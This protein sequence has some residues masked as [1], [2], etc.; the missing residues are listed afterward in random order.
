MIVE[1]ATDADLDGILALESSF[2]TPWSRDSWL[3]ELEGADRL[4]LAAKRRLDGALIGAACFRMVDEVADLNRIVVSPEHRRL[5]LARVMI[6]AGLQW[7]ISRG[8]ARMLLEVEHTNEPAIRL[9]RGYGFKQ[10]AQRRDY[11]APGAHALIL[12]RALEGVDVDSVGTW[13]MEEVDE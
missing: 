12:E 10:I 9:Y 4:V 8:A 11:Y 2:E 7:A 6:V 13:D 3:A 1:P 5:G